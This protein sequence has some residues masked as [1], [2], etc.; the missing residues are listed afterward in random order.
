M[1]VTKKLLVSLASGVAVLALSVPAASANTGAPVTQVIKVKT[2]NTSNTM[3]SPTS[4]G[5]TETLWQGTKKVG[6]DA[7]QCSFAS[8]KATTGQCAGVLWFGQTGS[9]FI[10]FAIGSSNTIHGRI[11]GGTGAY[12]NARGTVMHTSSTTNSKIGWGTLRFTL[13][14]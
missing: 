8:Q 9:F 5:F 7:I 1:V 13:A 2:V 3:P 4:F 10:S 6:N 11:D 14:P 12:A